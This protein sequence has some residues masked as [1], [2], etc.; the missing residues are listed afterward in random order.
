MVSVEIHIPISPR[1]SFFTMVHFLAASLRRRGGAFRDAKIVVSVGEDCEP[2]DLRHGH[3][4]LS[5]YDIS[6]R[7][8]DRTAFRELSYFA[9]G[10]R[11][12]N[13]FE[14]D[15]VIMADADTLVLGDISEALRWLNGPRS[16]C[17]VI[18]TF[19][20]F[21]ARGDGNTDA[22]RWLDLF[23]RAALSP[24]P[25]DSVHPGF[26]HFYDASQGIRNAPPY[27]N[28]GFVVGAREAMDSIAGTVEE[29][30]RTA[31][32]Y[33]KSDLAA[34][35][36]LALS[37]VRHQ[38]AYAS[39]PVR[40]NM[41]SWPAYLHAFPE[42]FSD[43]RLLHYLHPEVFSKSRDIENVAVLRNWL[44]DNRG[45]SETMTRF[46]ADGF[47]AFLAEVEEDCERAGRSGAMPA[48]IGSERP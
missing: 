38:V 24:P 8:A 28:Y 35:A 37:I 25:F 23:E 31:A 29:D 36:G 22:V 45:S 32:A 5:K 4:E 18:A 46:I 42:D 2:F 19:P 13:G 12:W 39:L 17:G 47:G 34:Q 30:Y 44:A 6:W 43:L 26:G 20:P 15:Y 33:M 11:R 41:W 14:S 27:Y 16:I 1:P 9:T 10:L 40:F 3:P 48:P 21:M 7:W